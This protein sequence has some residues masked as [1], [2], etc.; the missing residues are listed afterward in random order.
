MRVVSCHPS[1]QLRSE[2]PTYGQ[3]ILP[4]M[5]PAKYDELVCF[6][7]D[8]RD[9]TSA[10]LFECIAGSRAYGTSVTGSD[11]DIR[12]IFAVP[13][14]AYLDLDVPAS[15]VGDDRGNVVYY[16][17]RRVIDLLSQANP[18][19]L[20]LLFMPDDCIRKTSTEM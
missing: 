8:F 5:P 4:S 18:N 9:R 7:D 16:S 1:R 19:I 14:G 6:L 11:V 13:A 3:V 20:E 15:Q 17:L 2:I 12:G 10:I